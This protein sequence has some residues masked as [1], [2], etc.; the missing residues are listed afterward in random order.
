VLM[1]EEEDGGGTLQG[2]GRGGGVL[3]GQGQGSSMLWDRDQGQQA[4]A[5]GGGGRTVSRVRAL[6]GNEKIAKC[7]A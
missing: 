1:L 5:A 3:R 7:G 2:R 6:G 4:A